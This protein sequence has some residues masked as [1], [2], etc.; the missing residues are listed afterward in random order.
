MRV[1]QR[2]G[3]ILERD[4]QLDGAVKLAISDLEPWIKSSQVPFFPE[5]TEHGLEHIEGVL[6][7]AVSLIRDEAWEAVTPSDAAVLIVATLLHDCAM[8]LSEDGFFQLLTPERSR[9]Q[10]AGMNDKPWNLLWEEFCGEASRFDGRKLTR[11]FGDAQPV[12]RPPPDPVQFT[13]RDRLLIGEFLRRHHSRLAQEIAAFGVPTSGSSPLVLNGLR[14]AREYIAGLSGIVARS[15]GAELRTSLPFL[16]EHFDIR[17]YK[18][19]HAVFLM[20]LL[21]VADYIQ[22]EAERAP[23]QVLRV[24]QLASPLSQGEWNAHNAIKDVRNTHEDPEALFVDAL[25]TDIEAFLRVE[26]WLRGIQHELDNSWAVLGEVYGRYEGL[27]SLGL[28]LRRVRSS[29]DNKSEFSKKVDFLPEKAFFRAADADLIKLLIEPLYGDHPEIGLRELI[30]NAVDAVRELKQYL[31]EVPVIRPLAQSNT[32]A[33]I[34]VSVSK[35]QDNKSFVLIT[36]NGIGMTSD[37]VINYFLTAG[38]SFRRSEGWRRLFETAEGKAKV[39]RA[40]RFGI[41]AL[42]SF[43]LGPEIEVYTRHCEAKRGICFRASVDTDSIELRNVD[44]P[45]GTS[46]RIKI[47]DEMAQ[48]LGQNDSRSVQ[49]GNWDWYALRTPSVTREYLGTKLAQEF[50]IPAAQDKMPRG[51]HSIKTPDYEDIHW[52]YLNAPSLICN[53]IRIGSC[54]QSHWRERFGLQLPRVSV[55]DRDGNLPLNLQRTGIVQDQYPFENALA[56]DVMRDFLAFALIRGPQRPVHHLGIKE[57]VGNSLYAGSG[58][59]FPY[60]GDKPKLTTDW[61]F[62]SDGF[63]YA[64]PLL[65]SKSGFKTALIAKID[66]HS[67]DKIPFGVPPKQAAQISTADGTLWD[68]DRTLRHVIDL[69]HYNRNLTRFHDWGSSEI[70]DLMTRDGCRFLISDFAWNRGMG[71]AAGKWPRGIKHAL[72]KEWFIDGWHLV[73]IGDCPR[74]IFDFKSFLHGA[75]RNLGRYTVIAEIY[76]RGK[77]S[78]KGSPIGCKWFEIF[79]CSEIPFDLAVRR[80]Q[81]KHA[82]AELN[83]YLE[84]HKEGKGSKA[85]VPRNFFEIE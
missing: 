79:K 5:Y 7:S 13:K 55:F 80:R 74:E 25:P 15:H 64:D 81:L 20:T 35:D 34:V 33:D 58:R 49:N 29:L 28:V 39:L 60:W 27:R 19:V 75:D 56:D 84:G 54:P 46:I 62:T 1:P 12:R 71:E 40:G 66:G 30:Q 77:Q 76:L 42:A 10:V 51:W 73:S 16:E 85:N 41:G 43:L 52:T 17:Q 78:S 21:R 65:L 50:Y 8:H 57:F 48:R 6:L 68:L 11:L 4:Q 63:G 38:A 82:Y 32:S 14:G 22:I 59:Y 36:D 72:S 23:S 3:Y 44:C 45:V 53:G 2:L 47:T 26:S 37:T 9:Q 61:Y 31:R 70:L 24:T 67:F 69:G 18:G 83:E